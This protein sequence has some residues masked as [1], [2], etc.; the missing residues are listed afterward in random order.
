LLDK[1]AAEK[2]LTEP[3][4][5][6]RTFHN[7]GVMSLNVRQQRDTCRENNRT[8]PYYG[9]AM[10]SPYE[11]IFIWPI[12][13]IDVISTCTKEASIACIISEFV[14]HTVQFKC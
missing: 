9:Y 7:I 10:F 8:L 5:A 3:E 13:D 11:C 12:H 6:W 14:L 2:R 1:V 4:E